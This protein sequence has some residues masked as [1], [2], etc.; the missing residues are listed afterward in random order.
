MY[1]TNT[2]QKKDGVIILISEVKWEG[3]L[4]KKNLG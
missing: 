3:R 1:W 2:K 4:W